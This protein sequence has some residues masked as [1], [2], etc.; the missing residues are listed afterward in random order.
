MV[1]RLESKQRQLLVIGLNP[2]WQVTLFFNNLI[3]GGV[4]RAVDKKSF[5]SGKGINFCRAASTTDIQIKLL[6][7]CG[8]NFGHLIM[9]DLQEEGIPYLTIATASESRRCTTCLSPGRDMTELIEPANRVSED[10]CQ[11]LIDSLQENI[12]SARGIMLCGTV[13]PGAEKLYGKVAEIA[14]K[15]IQMF[16]DSC[17][18]IDAALRLGAVVLKINVEELQFITGKSNL[19]TAITTI[20]ERYNLQYLAITD[21]AHKAYLCDGIKISTFTLP[22]L[23]NIVSTLGAGDTCSAI[24]ISR[25]LEGVTPIEAFRQA[26]GC[27]SA[28]C[29]TDRCAVF[30][31]ATAQHITSQITIHQGDN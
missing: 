27:A 14:R 8:G 10:E 7:F 16:I 24:F 18:H 23:D 1:N 26:L 15:G 6:Q 5:A 21:G 22:Q 4:N 9:T 30:D 20:F 12:S 19:K 3:L 28:S 25:I 11:Q 31:L 29:L 2:V 17:Q 13:P